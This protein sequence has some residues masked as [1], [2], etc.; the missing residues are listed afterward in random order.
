MSH[1]DVTVKWMTSAQRLESNMSRIT[2][3]YEKLHTESSA[4]WDFHIDLPTFED[5]ESNS[6]D[7]KTTKVSLPIDEFN[8]QVESFIQSL[9]SNLHVFGANDQ[10]FSLVA[11]VID[12]NAREKY[13]S[14]KAAP[15]LYGFG[16]GCENCENRKIH[17]QNPGFGI[18]FPI[19]NIM[20]SVSDDGFHGFSIGFG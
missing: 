3:K 5:D 9:G 6:V 10:V 4:L 11:P 1:H 18:D 8:H 20:V 15:R 13:R 12:A 17:L 2:D 14:Q 19:L 16:F 7:F